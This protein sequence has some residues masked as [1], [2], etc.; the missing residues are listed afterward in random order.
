MNTVKAVNK[1]RE[2]FRHDGAQSWRMQSNPS[3]WVECPGEID[4]GA[5][6]PTVVMVIRLIYLAPCARD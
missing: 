1:T 5:V 3:S 4:L 2:I 6:I